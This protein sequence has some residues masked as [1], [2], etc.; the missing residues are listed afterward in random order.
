MW[1]RAR[2]WEFRVREGKR[3]TDEDSHVHSGKIVNALSFILFKTE[4]LSH[5]YYILCIITIRN[6]PKLQK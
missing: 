6:F 3:S 4:A 2:K 5:I 1:L